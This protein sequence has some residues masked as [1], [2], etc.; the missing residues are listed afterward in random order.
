MA[1]FPRTTASRSR[2][3]LVP[4]KRVRVSESCPDTLSI[5]VRSRMPLESPA[6]RKRPW[7]PPPT[8]PSSSSSEEGGAATACTASGA[9]QS[10]ASSDRTRTVASCPPRARN[11]ACRRPSGMGASA[12]QATSADR[13]FS[14]VWA[15][16]PWLLSVKYTSSPPVNASTTCRAL[17]AALATCFL[18]GHRHSFTLPSFRMCRSPP[19]CTC[20]TLSSASSWTCRVG[21]LSRNP[22]SLTSSTV[23]PMDSTM[24]AFTNEMTM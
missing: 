10:S 14:S 17:L 18:P 23:S 24:V 15:T 2:G 22:E 6:L 13:S 4:R 19:L 8:P 1:G 9:R 12:M 7:A 11:L 5:S 20:S 21:A 16:C 3:A